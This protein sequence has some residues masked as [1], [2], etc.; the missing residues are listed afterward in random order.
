MFVAVLC[1]SRLCY[2]E[3]S[4]SQRKAEFYRALVN[5][6]EFFRRQSRENHFRQPEGGGDQRL[7][8]ACLPASRVLG[9][10]RLLLH[11]T[12]RLCESATRNRKG[13]WRDSVRYVKRSALAGRGEELVTWEDYR[14]LGP[15]LARRGG[16]RPPARHHPRAPHRPF[17]ERTPAS[18]PLPAVPFDTD[19]ILSVAG[20]VP[21]PGPLR[22][23]PLLR[24]AGA[25]AQDGHAAG[26]RHAIADY[27]SGPGGGRASTLLRRGQIGHPSRPPP[28]GLEDASAPPGRAVRGRSSTPSARWRGS[29]T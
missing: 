14:R 6:L 2:I 17:R 4:L 10:L 15:A 13:S 9:P 26:Q 22:R 3:F 1:Y 11:G 16:Q 18:A 7:G 29:S 8:A 24:A 23:Q 12:D 25:G 5:A 20:H 28:G 19:E 27:R 21:C